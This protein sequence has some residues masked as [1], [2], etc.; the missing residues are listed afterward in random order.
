MFKAL[1]QYRHFVLSSIRNEYRTRFAR[2]AF[3]GLWAILNPLAEVAI[4]ALI[5]SNILSARFEGI[6]NPY[7]FAIYLTSGILAW[8][9]FS[10]TIN[11]CLGLFIANGNLIKKVMFPKVVLPATVTGTALVDNVML[12]I[13]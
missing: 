6:D 11:R 8:N 9:L 4:Y 2:S 10:Q 1:W 7:S 13:A 3:G 12:L 5:L